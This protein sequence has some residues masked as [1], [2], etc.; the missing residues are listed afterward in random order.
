M[1]TK[2]CQLCGKS[3]TT[4]SRNQR[5]CSKSCA[6]SFTNRQRWTEDESFFAGPSLTPDE[7]YLIG[8][9]CAD[10]CIS[11]DAHSGRT[12]L[13]IASKDKELLEQLRQRMTPKKSLYYNRGC[14]YVISNNMTDINFLISIGILENKSTTIQVPPIPKDLH[15]HFVRGVFDGDGSV[16]RSKVRTVNG[17]CYYYVGVSITTGSYEFATGLQ[18]LLTEHGFI[19]N[20]VLDSRSRKGDKNP[21]WYIKL[22]R[23]EMVL[24]FYDWIYADAGLYM[25]SKRRKFDSLLAGDD[26]VRPAWQQA[27][28]GDKEL[29]G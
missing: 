25:P 16:Y 5:F 29:L 4:R 19:A 10:G 24:K 9:I 11:Y 7:A 15:P 6:N 22:S 8:L 2:T 14:Y 17:K 28:P 1:F 18:K 23:T 27:E 13:T 20:I 26:I 21:T 12:R 3:F